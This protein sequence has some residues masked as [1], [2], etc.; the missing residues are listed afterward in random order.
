MHVRGWL[1]SRGS[2]ALFAAL[3]SLGTSARADVIEPNG[4]AVPLIK[5]GSEIPL[6]TYFAGENEP[7]DAVKDAHAVP[8]TFSPL[9]GFSATLVL[10][11]SGS[12]YGVGYYNIMANATMPPSAAEIYQI[13]P[14]GSPV[15]TAVTGA[16]IRAEPHYLGGEV[17]FALIRT[18][19]KVPHFTESEWNTVCSLWPCTTGPWILSLKYLSPTKPNTYYVAF[20][21]GDTSASGWSNDGDFNDYVFR[22][23]GLTCAGGAAP[24]QVKDQQGAC[25]DGLTECDGTGT[26]VCKQLIKAA[27][28]VCDGVD[29]DCNGRADDGDN[30]CP[31]G[32]HCVRGTCVPPCGSEFPCFGNAVCEAGLCVD[33]ACQSV[34][35]DAGKTCVAGRCQAPCDGVK[36]PGSQVCRVGRCVEPC[37]GVSCGAG[38]VCSSGVCVLPCS[39]SGC[40][41]GQACRADG[42]CVEPG[43]ETQTCS[44]TQACIAGQCT[45]ACQGAVCPLGGSCSLGQCQSGDVPNQVQAGDGGATAQWVSSS[46]DASLS[47]PTGA[48]DSGTDAAAV[49]GGRRN[50]GTTTPTGCGCRV[51]PDSHGESGGPRSLLLVLGLGYVLRRRARRSRRFAFQRKS[52]STSAPTTIR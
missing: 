11:Q 12:S 18:P 20:E 41:A 52:Q 21:D 3:L 8:E 29:N 33:P 4:V 50:S 31:V 35:C 39:C 42:R 43:C 5:G 10:K 9:C 16:T 48:A 14:A 37:D 23:T 6:T 28:E 17:G 1:D 2:V 49:G 30:L 51:L 26:L 27:V 46:Q 13:V 19:P 40:P 44:A 47:F 25:V 15:G 34:T 36:C 38:N 24:C 22:F 7:I 45:D 32:K